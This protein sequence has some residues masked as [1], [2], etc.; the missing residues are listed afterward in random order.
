MNAQKAIAETIG[1]LIIERITLAA[2]LEA[3]SKELEA[4][5]ELELQR[6]KDIDN[7]SS[8]NVEQSCKG[9]DKQS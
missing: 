2:Q 4:Y 8:G 9:T 1:Q 3:M 6:Q 7:G 5:K